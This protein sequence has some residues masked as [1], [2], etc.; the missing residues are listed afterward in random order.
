MNKG[1]FDISPRTQQAQEDTTSNPDALQREQ[2]A[3][4]LEQ[5][6]ELKADILRQLQNGTPPESALYTACKC[7]ALLT[8][9]PDYFTECEKRLDVVYGDLAQ[10]SLEADKIER[11]AA[12]LLEQQREAL[13]KME[14]QATKNLMILERLQ[15][16]YRQLNADITEFIPVVIE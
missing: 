13:Q 9:E 3:E 15:D 11:T 10:Q 12:A 8:A 14:K 16:D 4:H 2:R 5:A 1:L 6:A 7:I